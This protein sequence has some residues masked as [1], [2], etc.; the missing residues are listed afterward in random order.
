M[1][2]GLNKVEGTGVYRQMTRSLDFFSETGFLQA[3]R[4][5]KP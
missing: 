3:K 5:K 2:G 1:D 4:S